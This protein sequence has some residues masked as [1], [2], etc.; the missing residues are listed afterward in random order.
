MVPRLNWPEWWQWEI[1][2][3]PHL[4]KRM[5]ARDFSEVELRDMLERASAF[6]P[7]FAEGR[8]VVETRHRQRKWEVV[9]EP[10]PLDR[11]L[12]IITAYRLDL[13]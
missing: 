9:V 6:R 5:E 13:P 11:L 8:W 3:T 2:L 1:E 7:D 12:V 10:D 4:F